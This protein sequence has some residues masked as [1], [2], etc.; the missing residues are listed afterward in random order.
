MMTAARSPLTKSGTYYVL[1]DG[2][3]T[4]GPIDYSSASQSDSQPDLRLGTVT[5]GTAEPGR[6][7]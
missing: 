7:R 6:R 5:N 1:V 4:Y 3:S 2:E